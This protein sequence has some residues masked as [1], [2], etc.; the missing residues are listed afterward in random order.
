MLGSL[1]GAVAVLRERQILHKLGIVIS[2]TIIAFACYKL[3]DMLHDL[4]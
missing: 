4:D 3:Y 1:R 2:I